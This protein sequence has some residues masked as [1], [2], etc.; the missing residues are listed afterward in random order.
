M[1]VVLPSHGV[2]DQESKHQLSVTAAVDAKETQI[3]LTPMVEWV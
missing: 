3:V 2:E 1:D